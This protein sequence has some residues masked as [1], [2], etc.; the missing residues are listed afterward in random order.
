MKTIIKRLILVTFMF[1]TSYG[2][3]QKVAIIG[4]NHVGT[5]GFTFLVTQDLVDGEVIYFTEN[6]YSDA[7]NAFT[8]LTEAV[9]VFTASGG[10]SKGNVVFVNE[11][12]TDV[13]SVSC[14]TGSC[15]S[16]VK[17]G[18]SSFFALATDGE[19]LYA[20]TDGDTDPLNGITTIYSVMYT[21]T[22]E[23]SVSKLAE[24]SS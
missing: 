1:I 24:I 14:T 3:A 10:I 4:M 21:G 23:P 6:E 11:I 8:D 2:F 19:A 15:G 9:V 22:T 17:L 12:S 13:F 7:A 20:Y 5:D 18:A 16:A